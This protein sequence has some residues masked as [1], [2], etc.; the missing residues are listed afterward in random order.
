ME[1]NKELL[2]NTKNPKENLFK[3]LISSNGSVSFMGT[4]ISIIMGLI[5]GFI[6][7]L[8]FNTPFA[9]EG[10]R[11]I[12]TTAFS[13]LG[14]MAK[15]LYEATPLIFV[16]LSVGFAFK[17]GL[18]NIGAP[19]QYTIGAAFGLIACVQ[20]QLPWYVC[21]V[22]A[23]IGGAIWG[24]FPGLFKA[25]FNVNEVITSI[26]FNWI[27]LFLVNLTFSNMPKML[28]VYWGQSN[29]DKTPILKVANPNGIIPQ[30][31]LGEWMWSDYANIGIFIAI[32]VAILI[33]IILNKTI[34]GYELKACGLSQN[35][36]IYAGIKAKR[37]MVLSMV[38]A[39]ALA[40]LGGGLFYL[41]G[42]E[43]YT[44]LKEVN[45]MGFNGIPVALLAFSNPIAIIFSAMFIALINVGGETL[46]PEF[47][48]ELIDI[49][50]AAII[51]F[52]AFSLLIKQIIRRFLKADESNVNAEPASVKVA[53]DS[54]LKVDKSDKEVT[55]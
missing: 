19:G 4:V 30:G 55:K 21:L 43:Q 24:I 1:N 11:K 51:Y 42:I 31:P 17:T 12:L 37:N 23:A 20:F 13:S 47:A 45:G 6:L 8:V 10:M 27:G 9:M 25:L 34:F 14:D 36:G 15:F 35:A 46:Q 33:Y 53:D 49:I 16:G 2:S 41:S 18:F 40:G 38:I 44:I 50:T 26:M 5:L 32:G 54:D 52:S 22:F 48:R 39:G 3:K 7:L 28:S 29:N